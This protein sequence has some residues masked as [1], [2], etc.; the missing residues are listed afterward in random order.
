MHPRIPSAAATLLSVAVFALA[1]AAHAQPAA[2]Q[3]FVSITGVYDGPAD[4]D[5]GG[6]V[7]A[8]RASVRAGA[9]RA[10]GPDLRAGLAVS[11]DYH[12]YRFGSPAAFGG[13]EPWGTVQRYGIGAPLTFALR[14]GWA[15]GVTPSIDVFR[16]NG[17]RDDDA[18]VWGGVVAV[19][20]RFEGGNLL[21][22]GLGAFDGLEESN[23]FP[24]VVVDWR[25]GERWRI[26]NPLASGPTGAGGLELVYRF[27]NGWDV[28]VG[29]AYRKLRFRLSEGGPVPSGVGEERGIPLFA[30]AS[31][32]FGRATLHAYAGMIVDGRLRVEDRDGNLLQ[33]SDYD[34]APMLGLTLVSRF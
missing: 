7:R 5:D 14:D 23:V 8:A 22:I 13:R 12:D 6:D 29:A 4:L 1:A 24:V 31:R 2:P 15:L 26:A 11:Y 21:G 30:K 25:L 18:V 28:G 33:Q 32:D 27:D 34:P 20:R 16:E 10:F 17:A 19:T 9:V 3:P